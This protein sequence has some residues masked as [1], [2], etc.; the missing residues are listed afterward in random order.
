MRFQKLFSFQI[1]ICN[2][3]TG[4]VVGFG[5]YTAIPEET[6]PTVNTF[7]TKRQRITDCFLNG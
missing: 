2:V 6:F 3:A 7:Y 1:G 5:F 4:I